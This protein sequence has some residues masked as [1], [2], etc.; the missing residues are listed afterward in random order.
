MNWKY[1]KLGEYPTENGYYLVALHTEATR[2]INEP[3]EP[4]WD[5]VHEGYFL[6]TGGLFHGAHFP[7]YDAYAWAEMPDVPPLEPP[8]VKND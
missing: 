6:K 8:E 7:F 1:I 2:S 5:G 3:Q 4:E